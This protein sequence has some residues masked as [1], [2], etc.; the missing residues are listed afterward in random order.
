VRRRLLFKIKNTRALVNGPRAEAKRAAF[1]HGLP[2]ILLRPVL[3]G[4]ALV[5]C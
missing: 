5:P 3:V 4:Y 2:A 1:I